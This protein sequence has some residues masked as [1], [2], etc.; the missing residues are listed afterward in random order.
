MTKLKFDTIKHVASF[1]NSPKE[2][3]PEII[4]PTK[5]G[6]A[7][8]SQLNDLYFELCDASPHNNKKKVTLAA[9]I[10]GICSAE[11]ELYTYIFGI[12]ATFTLHCWVLH[13]GR[14]I[15][16]SKICDLAGRK[17]THAYRRSLRPQMTMAVD[18][19]IGVVVVSFASHVHK[20]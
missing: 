13:Q 4:L 14:V 6:F 9:N 17:S 12:T 15:V 3:S 1:A 16:D 2:A 19:D 18:L 11:T 20:L 5:F 7:L 8:L 10:C